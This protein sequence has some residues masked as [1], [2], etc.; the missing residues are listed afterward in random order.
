M[1]D[2]ININIK[3]GKPEIVE[4][5]AVLSDIAR[6]YAHTCKYPILLAKV[7]NQLEE[8][9]KRL[10]GDCYI[11]FLDLTDPN[12]YRTYQR[13]VA[14][15]MIC[16]AKEILGIETRIVV[17]HSINKNYY[18]ELTRGGL[19]LTEDMVKQIEERMTE[20][21]SRD[22]PIKKF[23]IPTEEGIEIARKMGLH[24]KER[25]LKYRRTANVNFYRLD[26]FYDYFY[27]HIVPSTGY[28][29]VF[30]LIREM[31]GLMLQFPDNKDPGVMSEIKPHEK[32]S[33]IFMESSKWAR[34]MK[35]DTVPAL[36]DII[37][38]R[39]SK[40]IIRVNEA[41]HEKKI[42]NLADMIYQRGKKIVLIAGPSSSGKTTFA[43][44]LAVQLNASG[45]TPRVISLDDY[46]LDRDKIPFGEDGTQDF[47][48]ID[49]FD[50][51]GFNNDVERL[52]KG[53]E[54]EI[55]HFNFLTGHRE[56]KGKLFKLKNTDVIVVEGIH[57]L[58][59]KVAMNVKHGV[60]FRIFISAL[61]QLSIDDHNRIPTSDTRLLRRLV[62]D[63]TTRGIDPA[64]NIGM[65][66]KV[67][68]SEALHIFPH[69]EN[70]DA[71]FNSALV[72]ELCVIKQYVEPLLFSIE[73]FQPEYT[74]A[75]RLLKFLD[76]FLTISPDEVPSNSLLREFIGGSS[77][78]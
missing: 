38:N 66:P 1:A 62:R 20:L 2:Y 8:L 72:Y 59:E 10:T 57:G 60:K 73:K 5:Y 58:N 12:G 42:S 33:R 45:L 49:A 39:G 3:D 7:N 28:L 41:L 63:V 15:L 13:S 24:D 19:R 26:W 18:C 32:I 65:W 77:F 29:K 68:Q 61:T 54:V 40:E 31:D 70:A 35:V 50:V 11:E 22:L 52:L 69:Q 74:E 14:F 44:R 21:V 78:S 75:R 6:R 37:C 67:A 53:E 9:T 16:A 47:E 36:N 17:E 23:S 55:P 76:S 34:I 4:K 64:V 71:M 51:D 43:N 56:Y 27:G 48:T 30:K 46:Y 25:F